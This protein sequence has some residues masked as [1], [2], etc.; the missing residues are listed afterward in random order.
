MQ[1]ANITLLLAGRE[2]QTVQKWGVTPS[3]IEVLRLKHGHD[4]VRD[5]EYAG[6][7]PYSNRFELE[8]L[9]RVYGAMQPSGIAFSKDVALLF[10]GAAARVFQTIDE[11]ELEESYIKSLAPRPDAPKPVPVDAE[12]ET[13]PLTRL[14]KAALVHLAQQRG[15]EVSE[16]ETKA[17]I[18]KA[19]EAAPVTEVVV[20][21]DEDEDMPDKNMFE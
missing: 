7:V 15:L 12:V 13:V 1:T 20:P 18:I 9:H 19:I 3:E 6:E 5:V 17:E 8:R 2:G 10:P 4:A 16:N 14:N 11:L 21:E